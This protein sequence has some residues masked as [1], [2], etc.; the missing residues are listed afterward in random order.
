MAKVTTIEMF[1]TTKEGF[2]LFMQK[3]N[4]I[5]YKGNDLFMSHTDFYVDEN[6]VV[7]AS[8]STSS[9][10]PNTTYRI[11]ERDNGQSLSLLTLL[12]NSKS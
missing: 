2:E 5:L 9:W 1:D 7:H 4:L 8:R 3:N 12:F 10:N 11:S 6:N